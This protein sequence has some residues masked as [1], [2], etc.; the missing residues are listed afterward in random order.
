MLKTKL[1]SFI[2]SLEMIYFDGPK[3]QLLTPKTQ[4]PLT[5]KSCYKK[6]ETNLSKIESLSAK[7]E[8][9][10]IL[11]FVFNIEIFSFIFKNF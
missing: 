7:L 10:K 6:F 9:I 8:W 4:F 1:K 5:S 11:R 3:Y 2:S